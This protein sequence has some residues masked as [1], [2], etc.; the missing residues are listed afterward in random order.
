[1]RATRSTAV[2][3]AANRAL[4]ATARKTGLAFEREI[5]FEEMRSAAYAIEREQ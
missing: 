4:A 3:G 2:T 1:M 5:D